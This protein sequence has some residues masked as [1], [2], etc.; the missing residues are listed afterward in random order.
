MLDIFDN[1]HTDTMV[2][3]GIKNTKNGDILQAINS[4]TGNVKKINI[5]NADIL[6]PENHNAF[7]NLVKE[8]LNS[9]DFWTMP[10]DNYAMSTGNV[11]SAGI[12][13]DVFRLDKRA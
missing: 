7:Y 3:V 6:T 2:T 9:N 11:H 12:E 10:N 5:K 13:H 4:D 8:M 1:T